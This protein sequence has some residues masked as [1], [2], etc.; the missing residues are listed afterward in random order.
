MSELVKVKKAKITSLVAVSFLA[1][2]TSF[3]PAEAAMFGREATEN[4]DLSAF[5]KWASVQQKTKQESHTTLTAMAASLTKLSF[6]EKLVQV[7][8]LINQKIA[9]VEDSAGWG[10]SD[11]W[12][13]PNET[14]AKGYGDCDDYAILK[15]FTLL[16]AGVPAESMRV[17]VLR[18]ASQGVL[19]AVL[20]VTEGTTNYILDNRFSTLYTDSTMPSYQPIYALNES[21]WWRFI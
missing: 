2:M 9:Y 15:Y 8:A 11:Y 16:Q 14:L 3:T 21:K 6:H 4:Q 18:D 13:T 12:A 17:V 19:H 20:A 7:N 10:Q 1:L 5:K